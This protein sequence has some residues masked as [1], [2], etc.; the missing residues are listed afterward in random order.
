MNILVR[1]EQIR[2]SYPLMWDNVMWSDE[3]FG[4]N[5]DIS[6]MFLS[7]VGDMERE[8]NRLNTMVNHPSFS[9]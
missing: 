6:H 7:I 5:S 4:V 9:L 1:L 8:W 3:T 2:N